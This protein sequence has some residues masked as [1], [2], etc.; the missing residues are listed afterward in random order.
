MRVS[1]LHSLCI[2]D[3]TLKS[4]KF[5]DL[6]LD[7]P[8]DVLQRLVTENTTLRTAEPDSRRRGQGL[9]R[10]AGRVSRQQLL[11]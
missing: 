6:E 10:P 1:E 5:R 2:D 3:I 4:K 8:A 9:D 7:L 11:T